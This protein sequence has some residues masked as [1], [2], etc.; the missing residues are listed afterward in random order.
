METTFLHKSNKRII[1]LLF[2]LVS[3]AF[4]SHAQNTVDYTLTQSD[5]T[6][7]NGVITA[8]SYNFMGN[9]DGTNLTIPEELGVTGIVDVETDWMGDVIGSDPFANKNIKQLTLPSSLVNIGDYVFSNNNLTELTIPNGVETIGRDAFFKNKIN[10]I[11]IPASLKIIGKNCFH[12]NETLSSVIIAENSHLVSIESHAF[13]NT[14]VNAIKLPTPVVPDN[15]FE[16]WIEFANTETI[17]E[18]GETVLP[19]NS[20]FRAKFNYTLTA[21]D[22]IVENGIVTSCSYDFSGKFIVIPSEINGVKI[23]GIADARNQKS[24]IFYGKTILGLTL[25]NTLET[26]GKFSF[27]SNSIKS[28][29]IP[30]SVKSIGDYAFW[31]FRL[32]TVQF[33]EKCKITSIGNSAFDNNHSLKMYF[34]TP[35]KEGYTFEKWVDYDDDYVSFQGGDE[36]KK[37]TTAYSARFALGTG[38]RTNNLE[39]QDILVFP[40]PVHNNLSIKSNGKYDIELLDINGRKLISKQA[41][42]NDEVDLSKEKSGTYILR[43]VNEKEVITKK[44]IKK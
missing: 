21:E 30:A 17:H 36:I 34:P 25:P 42:G 39:S 24:A 8:C 20:A 9:A 3:L 28:L 2:S 44:I 29:V 12:S 43:L 38:I 18:G 35:V 33:E 13:V 14:L 15:N 5:V 37:F 19:G 26:I 32:E 4:I 27:N 6:I 41:D 11:V 7:K 23:T 31:G 22:L 10:S 40:N 1:T 16:H